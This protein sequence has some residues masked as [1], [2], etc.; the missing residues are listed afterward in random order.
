[1]AY[2]KMPFAIFKIAFP[3]FEFLKFIILARRKFIILATVV[4]WVV[5]IVIL[6]RDWNRSSVLFD[7]HD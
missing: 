2:S 1:M 6:K 7:K 4:V 5:R 3:Y